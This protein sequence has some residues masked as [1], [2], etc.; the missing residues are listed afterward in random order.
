M[1]KG[2]MGKVISIDGGYGLRRNMENLGMRSGVL[3][4]KKSTVYK[5]GPVIVELGGTELAIGFGKA[6]KVT[7][8]VKD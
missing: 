2:E 1:K 5:R 8:E 6:M 4:K 3:V 7:V